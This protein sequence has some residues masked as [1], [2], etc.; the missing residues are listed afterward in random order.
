MSN[1]MILCERHIIKKNH[2]F[3]NECDKLTVLA[4]NLYNATLYYQRDSLFNKDFK[5]YYD[6]NRMFIH[7]NQKDYRAL[8]VRVSNQVLML[9]DKS[10]KSYF[11]L[12]KKKSAGGY[13]KECTH[14][15]IFE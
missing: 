3:Y 14:S 15:K 10:F 5:N 8:P 1:V 11:A 13:K 12:A 6:V 2:S 4:K 7:S 9:V